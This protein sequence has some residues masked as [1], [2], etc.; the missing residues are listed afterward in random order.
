MFQNRFNQLRPLRTSTPQPTPPNPFTS[1]LR[2][3]P[4]P[5]FAPA[6]W[7]L[8]SLIPRVV[9]PPLASAQV[10]NVVPSPSPVVEAPIA[11]QSVPTLL[12]E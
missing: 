5:G 8:E 7:P 4:M 10:P 12:G 3:A 6:P 9:V 11:R 1:K 2:P